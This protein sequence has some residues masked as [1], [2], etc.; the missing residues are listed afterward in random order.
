MDMTF[1]RD[2]EQIRQAFRE[3]FEAESTTER[4]RAAEE[5]GGFDAKLWTHAKN[6]GLL[7]MATTSGAD[8]ASTLDLAVVAGEA[9]R[10]LASIPAVEAMV[11]ARLLTEMAETA[12]A[13]TSQPAD[14]VHDEL[15][16]F[17]PRPIQ[18]GLARVV[19]GGA[20]ADAV[21]ALDGDRLVLL[22]RSGSTVRAPS[23]TLGGT[24]VADWR[25]GDTV[26]TLARGAEA[27]DWFSRARRVW[28]ALSAAALAG[29]GTTAV[30]LGTDYSKQRKAF[31]V[32]ISMFQAVS[33]R[34]VDAAVS[35]DGA[36][37]LS[38][39]AAWSLDQPRPSDWL[40]LTAFYRAG[41]AAEEAASVSLHVHG[42]YGVS[43]EYDIQ[44]YL[45]RA[46]T[47]ALAL[48]DRRRVLRQAADVLYGPVN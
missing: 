48:G 5:A 10:H 20:V 43:M 45:R 30:Q 23:N 24:P 39:E 36:E 32:L 31:G 11:A 41:L 27:L 21:I 46:K 26:R 3:L 42:G 22:D 40:P 47:W 28:L 15:V 1:T 35:I 6:V 16:S 4:V 7:D 2:Q 8:G 34:L 37:L 18:A 12:E 33:H 17:T 25:V 14:R 13:S 29:L 19:P 38:W 9:G 44:L